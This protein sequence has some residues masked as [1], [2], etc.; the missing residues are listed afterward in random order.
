MGT[1]A[2]DNLDTYFDTITLMTITDEDE[3]LTYATVTGVQNFDGFMA[4]LQ[5]ITDE[6]R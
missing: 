3:D 4:V 5:A 6:G 1:K 2:I